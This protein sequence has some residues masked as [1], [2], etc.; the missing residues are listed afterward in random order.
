MSGKEKRS[1]TCI[2]VAPNATSA[3]LE[4]LCEKTEYLISVTAVTAEYF[5]NL[6]DGHE[7]KKFRMLSKSIP[8]PE[9]PW[10]PSSNM[11]ASTSGTEQ[12]TDIR[13]VKTT[14][15]SVTLGWN[16]ARVLGSNRLLGTV[17]RWMEVK[18]GSHGN[19]DTALAHHKTIPAETDGVTIDGLNV[20]Q[21]YKFVVEAV[22]SIKTTL[23]PSNRSDPETERQN[24]RTTHVLS[25]P[26][27]ARTR[28]PCEPPKPVITGFTTNTVQ[29]YWEKPSMHLIAGKDDEGNPKHLKLALQGYRL[30]ING[31]PHMRLSPA[32]QSCTLI[33]CKPGKTYEVVLVALTCTADFDR[34][35]RKEVTL[36]IDPLQLVNNVHHHHH[37]L[38]S[39]IC[40]TRL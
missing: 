35:R 37:R 24:R 27:L 8:A 22:V 34:Q 26:I 6:P 10:L 20:G 9:D 36:K 19:Q 29:L 4:N 23:D 30:E 40:K 7:Q 38:S 5:D 18:P 3:K 16:P 2:E 33:K 15:D 31:K 13:V 28:A 14:P 39:S 21:M 25:K 11:I 17:V 32:A 1:H 12:P